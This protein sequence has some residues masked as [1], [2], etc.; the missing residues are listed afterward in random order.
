MSDTLV[1]WKEKFI[2]KHGEMNLAEVR[3]QDLYDSILSDCVSPSFMGMTRMI[4]FRDLIIKTERE[5][6]DI[7]EKEAQMIDDTDDETAKNKPKV[8]D[9]DLWIETL[10]MAP[11]TNFF[12]FVGNKNPVTDLEKWLVENATIHDFTLPSTSEIHSSIVRSL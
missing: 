4:I 10:K 9:D 3:K 5:I 7:Q 6:N 1:A 12:L 2:E 11:N 8:F